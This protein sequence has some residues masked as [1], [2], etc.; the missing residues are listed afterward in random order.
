MAVWARTDVRMAISLMNAKGDVVARD[1]RVVGSHGTNVFREWPAGISVSQVS[2]TLE[3]I[4]DGPTRVILHDLRVQG[5][6]PELAAYVR[7]E[8]G[9]GG[10]SQ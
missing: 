8:M 5:Q 10:F 1:E 2:L 6:T 9:S 3:A 4:G 7:H